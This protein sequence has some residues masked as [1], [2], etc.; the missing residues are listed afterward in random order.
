MTAATATVDNM[1]ISA[2]LVSPSIQT[3]KIAPLDDNSDVTVEVGNASEGGFGKLIVQNTQSE[4]VASID[5]E[6]NA[7]FSGELASNT[8]EVA[9]EATIGGTLYADNINS[10]TLDDIQALLAQ[11]EA[12][13]QV[14]AGTTTAPVATASDSATLTDL[15]VLNQAAVNSL[16]IGSSIAVGT[17]MV[18]QTGAINTISSPLSIQSLASAPVEIMAGKLRIETNGDV[19]IAGNLNVAGA[20]NSQSLTVKE[21]GDSGFGKL[22]SVVDAQGTEVASIDASGSA[23]FNNISLGRVSGSSDIREA[24][25]ITQ[26]ATSVIISRTW[27]TPPTSVIVTPSY[28]TTSWVTDIS[29]NGFTINVATDPDSPQ[30]LFFWAVW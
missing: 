29:Q 8:L 14:L 5:S 24:V 28:N 13:Q 10:Q 6:G 27:E 26:E 7:T 16:S 11:V 18:I 1:I 23:S 17:D 2:G 15:Y 12:D 3:E 9:S 19:T 4:E 30:K 21:T 25:D 22:I 20:I